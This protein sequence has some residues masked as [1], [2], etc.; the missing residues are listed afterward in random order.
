MKFVNEFRQKD[1]DQYRKIIELSAKLNRLPEE[2]SSSISYFGL[3]LQF[4][5]SSEKFPDYTALLEQKYDELMQQL[6]AVGNDHQQCMT[7][8]T[9]AAGNNILPTKLPMLRINYNEMTYV[10][11]EPNLILPLILTS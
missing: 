5:K 2:T 3:V 8:S 11:T 7:E 6:S 9:C 10:K 4:F 1:H